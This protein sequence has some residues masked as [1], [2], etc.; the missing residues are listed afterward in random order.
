MTH[1]LPLSRGEVW[2]ADFLFGNEWVECEVSPLERGLKGCVT[3]RCAGWDEIVFLLFGD[4]AFVGF[5]WLLLIFRWLCTGVTHPRPLSRGENWIVL[6]C[7]TIRSLWC[8]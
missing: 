5:W 2:D 6:F 7:L 8:F 1:P 3:V 4:V